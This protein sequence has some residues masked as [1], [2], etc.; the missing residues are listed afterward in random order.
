MLYYL[1]PYLREVFF[2]FNVLRY[3]TFRSV[4]AAV[5]SFFICAVFG[6]RFIEKFRKAGIRQ[7]Q[8]KG[9][10]PE[11]DSLHRD[12]MGT[13]TMGGIFIAASV[14]LSCLTWGNLSNKFVLL[15]LLLFA[16]FSLLGFTDDLLKLRSCPKGLRVRYKLLI[17]AAIGLILGIYLFYCPPDIA[18][19]WNVDVVDSDYSSYL[20]PGLARVLT[21]PFCK[22]VFFNLS[23]FYILFVALVIVGSSNAVNLTDGLDG[24]AVGNVIF[25]AIVYAIFSYVVGNW[26]ISRYLGILFVEGSGELTVFCSALIGA[27]LGFLWFNT[28]P[29]EVFMG[30][31]GS[32]ALGGAIGVVAVITKQELLLLITGGIFVAEAISV[33]IQVVSFKLRKKRVFAIAPLHHHFEVRG[34]AE[35]KVIVRFWIVAAIL[36]LFS[37]STLKLR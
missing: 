1:Y 7:K 18:V 19:L 30:D 20:N 34:W 5:T 10:S 36:A 25:V 37:L 27:G 17:Q 6:R 4:F 14:V 26:K 28:Y 21:I 9:D 11:L 3:I 2:G 12:K 33:I 15:T 24:L 22:D 35:P 31:T 13:P 16:G 23:F 8:G 32:L 29:A